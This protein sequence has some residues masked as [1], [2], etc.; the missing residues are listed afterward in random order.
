MLSFPGMGRGPG[1]Q[2]SPHS[3]F[4]L[5][6]L[7][8]RF[9][10]VLM[11]LVGVFFRSLLV[12]TGKNI[13]ML[14]QRQSFCWMSECVFPK[15]QPKCQSITGKLLGGGP[16]PL[17]PPPPQSLIYTNIPGCQERMPG[18]L[19]LINLIFLYINSKL[20]NQFYPFIS[21]RFC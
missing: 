18:S 5:V 20:K 7:F 19:G 21:T 12:N 10:D 8:F 6:Q 14:F 15:S 9:F 16:R 1:Q 3:C 4:I 17:P 2:S 13:C 11:F